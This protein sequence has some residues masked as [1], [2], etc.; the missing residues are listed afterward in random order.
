MH[1]TE[2]LREAD[3][4]LTICNACR[5]C[6]GLCAVFPAIEHHRT[7][8]SAD[9]NYLAN[10]CHS[11]GAC[12]HDCQFSPP[13]EFE[14]NVPRTLAE[15]RNESYARYVWPQALAPV[16]ARNGL[17]IA[18]LAALSV[19]A[20]ILGFIAFNNPG[21]LFS[22]Q[23]GE[24]AFYRLMPH[25]A[26]VALFG[27]V[28]L[29]S[30]FALGMGMRNFWRDTKASH[31]VIED[32]TSVWQAMRDAGSLRYL[33]GGGVGCFNEDDRPTDRRRLYH[34]LTFYGFL[35][36]FAATS[37]G[38]LY[39]YLFGRIA[40]YPW[41]D[42]P[43]MLGKAG[44]IML[45]VGTAG[46]MLA[47][48]KRDPVLVDEGRRGMDMAFLLM[49]FLTA[50]TGL[51]LHF[52]RSTPAMGV[53]LAVH[54]GVVFSFFLSMPYGKFVHG[55]YRFAALC[56]YAMARRH[57]FTAPVVSG[58]AMERSRGERETA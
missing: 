6:E 7:F 28:F 3:R 23:I 40:P 48:G 13:H 56:R 58:P 39:H 17:V 52:L 26:M 32:G 37:V 9:L 18:V 8:A 10:L 12:Y 31:G 50:A 57:G 43:P 29:Y 21:E 16:F 15:V 44:G 19:A 11:C 27:G 2:A 22:A 51:A 24:G 45:V 53:M 1:E 20:F 5:Y 46:L 41:W 49:L 14:V 42:L 25:D 54:L 4:Q 38:T 30:L 47:R 33:D 34:H 55:L 35:L 36:C